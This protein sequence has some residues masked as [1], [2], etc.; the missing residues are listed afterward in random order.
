MYIN[1]SDIEM[2]KMKTNIYNSTLLL[3]LPHYIFRSLRNDLC[4]VFSSLLL[5]MFLKTLHAI[6]VQR[7]DLFIIHIQVMSFIE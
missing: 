5:E 6:R 1:G 7:V 3:I 4:F 2:V